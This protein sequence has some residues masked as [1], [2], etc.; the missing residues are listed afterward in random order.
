[1]AQR[2]IQLTKAVFYMTGAIASFVAMAVAGRAVSFQLD[3]FEIMLFRSFIGFLLVLGFILVRGEGKNISR[4][5]MG[6]HVV[7]NL[8]HF[9]GQN[10]WFFALTVIP[11]AQVFALEFTTPLWILILSPLILGERLSRKK[12]SVGLI[13]FGGALLVAQPAMSGLSLGVISAALAAV[14]FACSIVLT[15]KL[16]QSETILTVLF[17]MTLFQLGFGII[18]AG[19]DGDIA[20]PSAQNL[21]WV[22]LIACAGLAAHFSLTAALS[23]APATLIAPIDFIRLPAIVVI[24]F[25]FYSEPVDALV[26]LGAG[27][28]FAANYVNIL[29][30]RN[31]S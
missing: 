19:Y 20:L 9:S 18:C 25:V 6:V 17:Y 8:F 10:L 30:E 12:I 11:L 1:M 29:G 5:H 13:G 28:I 14:G 26:I 15:K 2:Q 21:P 7:R 31:P 27:I 23:L 16:T 24:G 4:R 3:T 22:I